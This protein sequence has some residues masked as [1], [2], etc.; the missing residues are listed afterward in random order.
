MD[1][2]VQVIIGIGIPDD[3]MYPRPRKSIDEVLVKR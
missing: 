3:P 1:L 2:D